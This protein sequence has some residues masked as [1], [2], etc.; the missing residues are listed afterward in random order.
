[1]RRSLWHLTFY[2][3]AGAFV[4]TA[5]PASGGHAWGSYHWERSSNPVSLT[6]GD[7]FK[8]QGTW[9]DHFYHAIGHDPDGNVWNDGFHWDDSSMLD[10]TPVPGGTSPR[11]CRAAS[12]TIEV[13][14]DSYGNNGW[15]GLAQIWVSGGMSQ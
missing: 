3:T 15:L 1:M 2:V 4:L 12:G 5:M 11:R 7:N 8:D 10:L 14:A 9:L 13:C 6:L